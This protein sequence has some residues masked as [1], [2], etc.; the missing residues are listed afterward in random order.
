MVFGSMSGA[1][2]YSVNAFSDHCVAHLQ[3]HG[4]WY[5]GRITVVT[6]VVRENNQT[7]R[8]GWSEQCKDGTKMGC[9]MPEYILL[10]R[11]LPTDR[12]NA[13]ADEPVVHSK[14]AYPRARWQ[15]DAHGFW[16]SSGYRLLT[17]AEAKGLDFETLRKIWHRYNGTHV[18]NFEEHVKL[19][20]GLEQ[21]G[22]L[23]SSFMLLD[24]VSHSE[25]VW[26]DV[27]RMRSLNSLQKRRAA[28]LHTCP[29]QFDIVD[30]LMDRYSNEDDLVLDIFGGLGTVAYRALLKNRRGYTIEL[31]PEYHADA[32][33]YLKGAEADVPMPSLFETLDESNGAA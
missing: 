5:M 19:A 2:M 21:A 26:D 23:P 29:L 30:R 17:P 14:T 10:F 11:K 31:S 13:Y 7:Y 22:V 1:G 28:E 9:G 33:S 25:F 15:F 3:K 27:V 8:L 16:R 24:P 4:L 32:V 18:Y 20:E 12:G 6:D